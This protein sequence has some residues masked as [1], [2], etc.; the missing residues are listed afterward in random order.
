[1]IELFKNKVIGILCGGESQ[2]RDVSLKSGANVEKALQSLGYKTIKI[3]PS[4]DSFDNTTCD[5]AF[6]CLHGPGYED[7]KIQQELENK[8]IAYTGCG[9]SS[10]SIGM[11]KLKTKQ[12]CETHKLPIPKYKI[13]TSQ[14]NSLPNIFSY[15]VILKPIDEG[16]SIDVFLADNDTELLNY[17]KE[18]IQKYNTFL[19][20]E[21]IEG[22]EITVG[23]VESNEL[24]ALPSLEIKTTKRFLDFEAKYTKGFTE[25]ILPAKISD[26]A[27]QRLNTVAIKLFEKCNCNGVAR[28]DFRLSQDEQPYIL[29][30]NTIPGLTKMSDLPAQAKQYGWSFE[31]LIECILASAIKRYNIAIK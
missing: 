4:R 18:L 23:I 17:S 16:S 1:M 12:L 19:L 15:P 31:Q 5:I 24:I 8:N 25:F 9:V 28:I 14:L 10:S 2:E 13:I 3:D 21:F 11:S 26:N 22:K 29:E 30:I 27:I 20:E 6:L 7:G